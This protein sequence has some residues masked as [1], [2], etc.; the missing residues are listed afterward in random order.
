MSGKSSFVFQLLK[1]CSI[2]FNPKPQ[3]I[4]YAYAV[5]QDK[6]NAFK[7]VEFVCGLKTV[8]DDDFFDHKINNL[9]IVDDLMDHIADNKAAAALFSRGIHHRNISVIFIAQNL[10]KQGV[11]LSQ[12][13]HFSASF[14]TA[15]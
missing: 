8:L 7:D 2:H 11:C 12:F 15:F 13:L 14:S 3:R 9:L 10:F 1:R 6:F 4:V 5:W